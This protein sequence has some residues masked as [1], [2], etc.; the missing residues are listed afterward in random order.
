VDGSCFGRPIVLYVLSFHRCCSL[1]QVILS[2]SRREQE[3]FTDYETDSPPRI[4]RHAR[5]ARRQRT[6]LHV[7][8][9]TTAS[10]NIVRK[11]WQCTKRLQLPESNA[12]AA[13]STVAA[14]AV[15]NI[16][17]TNAQMHCDPNED[18][19]PFDHVGWRNNTS[20]A[21]TVMNVQHASKRNSRTADRS[22]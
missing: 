20:C 16:Q 14:P 9:R 2:C 12:G 1:F 18:S 5:N 11:W 7:T 15:Q 4:E 21:A 10:A 17:V 22:S 8:M 19:V 3:T 13:L 6:A